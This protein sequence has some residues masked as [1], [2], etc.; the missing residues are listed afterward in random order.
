MEFQFPA[1]PSRSISRS[2]SSISASV[3]SGAVGCERLANLR[4]FIQLAENAEPVRRVVVRALRLGGGA[5]LAATWPRGRL[6]LARASF[7]LSSSSQNFSA[8]S[9]R[10][11]RREAAS[12]MRLS[13]ETT[14]SDLGIRVLGDD[15][16]RS[17]RRH[18][19]LRAR[20]AP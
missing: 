2:I 6:F 17:G 7:R 10:Q 14:V 3:K 20:R 12:R 19:R 18:S 13:E 11:R 16:L 5:W 1:S 8:V 4:R 9:D 15:L